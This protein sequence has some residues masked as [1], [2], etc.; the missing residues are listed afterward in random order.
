MIITS[1]TAAEISDGDKTVDVTYSNDAGFVY[2]RS[3]NIPR[4]ENGS[5]DEDTYQAIL[6]SQLAGV[7]NKLAVGI[8]SF[9]D[10]DVASEGPSPP[11]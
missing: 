6:K 9:V 3:V 10:P 5:I 11:A 4:L 8:I 2:K 7:N 1:Y